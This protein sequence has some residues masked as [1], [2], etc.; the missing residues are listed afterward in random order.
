MNHSYSLLC[1]FRLIGEEGYFSTIFDFNAH[2]L[3]DG[4]HGWY[5]SPEIDFKKWRQTVIESQMN[6]QKYGFE[7]NITENHDEPRGASRILPEYAR[8][9]VQWSDGE[10][11]GFTTGKPWLKVNANYKAINVAVQEKDNDSVLNYYR[12][13]TALRKSVE[14]KEVFTYGEFVPAYEDTESV[15]AY[16][17]V[18]VDK[19]MLVAVNFGKEAAEIELAYPVRRVVLSNRAGVA[20]DPMTVPVKMLRLEGCEAIVLECE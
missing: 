19:R 9:P 15:M 17:R 5:D 13:L 6:V 7:A 4:K 20:A 12:R 8:T 2:I 14:Y 1:K 18:D 10:N 3:S 16:Y 11:A